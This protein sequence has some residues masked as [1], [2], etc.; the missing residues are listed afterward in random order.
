MM[1]FRDLLDIFISR[2]LKLRTVFRLSHKKHETDY[3]AF[4][5]QTLIS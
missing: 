1:Y 5:T 4:A 3:E 2:E